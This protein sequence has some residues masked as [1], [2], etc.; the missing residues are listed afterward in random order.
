VVQPW[1]G[2]GAAAH[3]AGCACCLRRAPLA[4]ALSRLFLAR[5]RGE[6]P[7]FGR[8]IVACP[9]DQEAALAAVLAA[10]PVTAAR[11][12]FAGRLQAQFQAGSLSS[13]S[14]SGSCM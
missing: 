9:P 2:Q 10:D 13:P 14:P 5:A 6:V 3:A 11:Y 4:V 7:L 8:V 1:P 12:R